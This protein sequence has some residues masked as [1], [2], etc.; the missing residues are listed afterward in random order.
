MSEDTNEKS[1]FQDFLDKNYKERHVIETDKAP[2]AIGPYSQAT[3]HGN[4]IFVSG[5][6]PI[7]VAT[8][9]LELN[10]IKKA[11]TN[12]MNNIKAI[13]EAAG[14]TMNDIVKTQIFL[15]DLADFAD[16]NEVYGSYFDKTFPARS[17]IQ[18]AGLPKG[19]KVEIE[20]IAIK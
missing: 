20:A 12:S 7:D 1:G 19:A 10:D 15:T 3:H 11:T 16:M 18:V 8:G 17:C 14:A 4:R 13:L 5:Q 2:G 6:L 9:E